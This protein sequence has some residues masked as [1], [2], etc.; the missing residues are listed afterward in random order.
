[1]SERPVYPVDIG[2]PITW[3]IASDLADDITG[4]TCAAMVRRLPGGRT[5]YRPSAEIILTPVIQSF[6]GDEYRG[7]GWYVVLYED[8]SASL[9]PGIYQMDADILLDGELVARFTWLLEAAI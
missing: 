9:D 1:M 7:P 8:E 3:V 4:Y 2:V 6:E 5:S